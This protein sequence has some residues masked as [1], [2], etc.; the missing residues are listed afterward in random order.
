MLEEIRKGMF[1]MQ[2]NKTGQH[3]QTIDGGI[4]ELQST[5]HE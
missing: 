5:S 4:E 1:I 3:L 2:I